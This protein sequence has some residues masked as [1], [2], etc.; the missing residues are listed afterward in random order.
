MTEPGSTDPRFR[1]RIVDGSVIRRDS[2]VAS[3]DGVDAFRGD[4]CSAAVAAVGVAG[5]YR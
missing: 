5:D 1:V 4:W 3:S 2:V